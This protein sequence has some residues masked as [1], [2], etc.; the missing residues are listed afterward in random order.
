MSDEF[1][2]KKETADS[3]LIAE[4][5]LQEDSPTEFPVWTHTVPLAAAILRVKCD[6]YLAGK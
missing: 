3:M 5:V 1:D 2:V 6:L 4:E